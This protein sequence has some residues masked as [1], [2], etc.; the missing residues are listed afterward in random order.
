MSCSKVAALSLLEHTGRS[1][2]SDTPLRFEL[3]T[4]GTCFAPV[5]TNGKSVSYGVVSH[6]DLV[7]YTQPTVP[8][9]P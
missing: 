9:V 3:S 4:L 6:F 2:W 7:C 5:R 1:R 8:K